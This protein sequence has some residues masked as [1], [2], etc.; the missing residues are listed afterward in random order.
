M[1]CENSPR[2]V[3]F[4]AAALGFVRLCCDGDYDS[5][6]P[7]GARAHDARVPSVRGG[8]HVFECSSLSFATELCAAASHGRV[9][10]RR[11]G[12][13]RRRRRIEY[14]QQSAPRVRASP[15]PPSPS[16]PHSLP[17][18]SHLHPSPLPTSLI[19]SNVQ[20]RTHEVVFSGFALR[21]RRP[22]IFWT[23][24]V[25]SGARGRHVAALR[26]RTVAFHS[27]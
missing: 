26:V 27:K 3:L 16:L 23:A 11:P 22:T 25:R 19:L 12:R 7:C 18:P 15:R 8:R 13:R 9:H 20:R 5:V 24:T 14:A 4:R 10:L 6:Q 1:T 17:L 21:V 2:A